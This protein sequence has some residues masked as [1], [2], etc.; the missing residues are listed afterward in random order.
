MIMNKI[1]E[2]IIRTI[3]RYH[4]YIRQVMLLPFYYVNWKLNGQGA[5]VRWVYPAHTRNHGLK[6]TPDY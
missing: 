1:S 3:E 6:Q 4:T 2:M 5:L